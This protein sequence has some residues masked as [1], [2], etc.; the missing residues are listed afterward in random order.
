MAARW[1]AFVTGLLVKI[2]GP[3]SPCAQPSHFAVKPGSQLG[4]L[5]RAHQ[6]KNGAGNHRHVGSTNQLEHAQ[7]V[8]HFLITPGVTGHYRDAQDLNIR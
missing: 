8:L 6:G 2:G 7:R 3:A 4:L 1:V 5:L